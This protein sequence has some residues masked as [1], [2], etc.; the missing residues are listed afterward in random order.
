MITYAEQTVDVFSRPN[1]ADTGVIRVRF[2]NITLALTLVQASWIANNIQREIRKVEEEH[3]E[4]ETP[5]RDN[6]QIG[7]RVLVRHDNGVHVEHTVTRQPW[8][9]GHGQLVLG[10][11]GISGGYSLN[12]VISFVKRREQP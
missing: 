2:S 8:E 7:D 3:P 12:R 9:L 6:I 1:D 10:I 11:S 5:N 4:L